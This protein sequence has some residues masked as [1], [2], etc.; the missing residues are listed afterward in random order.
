MHETQDDPA[1]HRERVALNR[2]SSS[3]TRQLSAVLRSTREKNVMFLDASDFSLAHLRP[4]GEVWP[5][6]NSLTDLSQDFRRRPDAE[7][8]GDDHEIFPRAGGEPRS[9]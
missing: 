5:G 4:L 9:Y 6:R 3:G 8:I 1:A 2:Q 7:T